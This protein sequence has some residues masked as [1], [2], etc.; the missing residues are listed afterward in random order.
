MKQ[1]FQRAREACLN[2]VR[3]IDEAYAKG[4]EIEANEEPANLLKRQPSGKEID[5]ACMYMRHD[6]GLMSLVDRD[7]LRYEAT[8]WLKAWS[9]VEEDGENRQVTEVK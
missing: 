2:L 9:K 3:Q 4:A 5:S 8:E 1:S 7:R 6:Y